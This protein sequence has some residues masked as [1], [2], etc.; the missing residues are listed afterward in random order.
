IAR[1]HRVVAIGVATTLL[2]VGGALIDLGPRAVRALR[3]GVALGAFVALV[4]QLHVRV[5]GLRLAARGG[6]AGG[7]VALRCGRRIRGLAPRRASR[8][9]ACAAH[10]RRPASRARATSSRSPACSSSMVMAANAASY[11][12]CAPLAATIQPWRATAP[13]T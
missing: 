11:Q 10:H 3:A 6:L 13:S 1:A 4:G 9:C 5:V 8:R 7:F 2:D 12:G